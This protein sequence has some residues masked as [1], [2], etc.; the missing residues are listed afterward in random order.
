[1]NIKYKELTATIIQHIE[2][3]PKKWESGLTGIGESMPVN[4]QGNFYNGINILLLWIA[5]D[6]K[7]FASNQWMTYK[8]AKAQ[9]ANVR[10]GEK[11]TQ[12]IFYKQGQKENNEGEKE[13]FRVMRVYTVFNI[14]QIDGLKQEINLTLFEWD[15]IQSGEYLEQSAECPILI[16]NVTP[17]Y[18]PKL[19]VIKI[20]ERSHF[21]TAE[22]YY[23]TLA[24]E[25]VHAT[26][27]EKRLDR[28][29]EKNKRGY[30]FEELV[31]ELGAVFT[32]AKLGIQGDIENHAS[33]LKSWLKAMQ[34]DAQYIFKA[35]T[36]ASKASD[37]LINNI[38]E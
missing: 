32:C 31:A 17:C 22:N 7:G 3:N 14:E 34:D 1:M 38:K 11:G 23:T 20:P 8:Q 28:L 36:L 18:S 12:I 29:N 24:H 21:D 10:K 13:T 6:Q 27:N 35:A 25:M 5:A 15:A 33:Y 16:E 26:G 9:D 37:L 30:A 19:D 2:S 4:S